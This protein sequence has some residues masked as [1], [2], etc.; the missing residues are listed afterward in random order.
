MQ[1]DG[2]NGAV[3]QA[4]ERVGWRRVEQFARLN[5]RERRGAAFV[6]IDR[7]PVH[8]HDGIAARRPVLHKMLEQAGQRRQAAA[9]GRRCCAFLL[10]LHPLPRDDGAMIDLAQRVRAS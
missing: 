8:V 9:H 1:A 2:E 7:R 5:F 4:G 10:A 6:A 3:A